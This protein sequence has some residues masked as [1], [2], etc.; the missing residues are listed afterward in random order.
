[1]LR[2][3]GVQRGDNVDTLRRARACVVRDKLAGEQ[4]LSCWVYPLAGAIKK[5]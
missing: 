5:K 4:D 2:V 3:V 1:V